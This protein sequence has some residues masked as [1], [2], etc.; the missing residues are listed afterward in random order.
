MIKVTC[1]RC[2][3]EEV[4]NMFFHEPVIATSETYIYHTK[5]YTAHVKGRAVCPSCGNTIEQ[6]FACP[7]SQSDIVELALRREIHV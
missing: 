4:V 6:D 3:S 1:P 2:K 5:V 7:L